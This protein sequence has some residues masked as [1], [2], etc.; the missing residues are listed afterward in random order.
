MDQSL[1]LVLASSHD[2]PAWPYLFWIGIIGLA[3]GSA[4][5]GAKMRKASNQALGAHLSYGADRKAGFTYLGGNPLHKQPVDGVTL[6]FTSRAFGVEQYPNG[7]L[8]QVP[9]SQI[10]SIAIE[11]EEELQHRIT[12]TRL[13]LTGIFAFAWKKRTG[14]SVIV[15]VD[16][17]SGP[18]LFEKLKATKAEVLKMFAQQ[19]AMLA[20]QV[21]LQSVASTSQAPTQAPPSNAMSVLKRLVELD[22]LKDEGLVS[23]VEYAERRTQILSDL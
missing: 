8:F 20:R 6:V 5:K 11:S 16:A 9:L 2:E 4:V 3:I 23:A 7:L 22:H 1:L 13:I 10:K 17:P 14:G 21:Q 18:L 12:V 19:R 15:S